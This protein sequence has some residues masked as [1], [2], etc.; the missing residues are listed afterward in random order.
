MTFMALCDPGDEII[1]SNPHYA[2]YPN[3]IRFGGG[4]PVFVSVYEE[5]GFQYRANAIREKITP[6][7]KGI[8]I[9]SPSNPTG[10]LLED[11]VIEQITQFGIPIISDEIYHGLIYS[12][13]HGSIFEFTKNAVALNG[14]SKLFAMT[15]WRLGWV[16]APKPMARALQK[17]QQN[18]F[19]CA[20]D[21]A[22]DAAATALFNCRREIQSMV[23]EYDRRRKM[24]L[25][26]VRQ[27]GLGVAVEPQGAFYIFLQREAHLSKNR[28]Q[29]QRT[30]L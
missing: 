4:T 23:Q 9:N 3:L 19:I 18:F 2:C 14:F 7:T 20:T 22:Q 28:V 25:E 5:D 6:R 1:L 15:G 8:L 12:G 24:T 26:R 13:Q 21:F 30:R 10:N 29:F 11:H 27:M 16:I 17:L